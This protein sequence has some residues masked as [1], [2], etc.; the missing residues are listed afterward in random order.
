MPAM[1]EDQWR[2]PCTWSRACKGESEKKVTEEVTQGLGGLCRAVELRRSYLLFADEETE[3]WSHTGS[4]GNMP[5][6]CWGWG[7]GGEQALT[8]LRSC[9][10]M[11]EGLSAGVQLVRIPPCP[12]SLKWPC[13]R[14]P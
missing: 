1:F 7:G 9:L 6:E 13:L 4:S 11:A 5:R 14:V 2:G 8:T 10:L 3:A 12:P